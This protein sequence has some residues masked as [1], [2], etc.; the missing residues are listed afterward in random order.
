ML[1]VT[2]SVACVTDHA[3]TYQAPIR[4][5]RSDNQDLC[6][7]AHGQLCAQ[8][9]ANRHSWKR[10][11]IPDW[12]LKLRN[13]ARSQ[14]AS[15]AKAYARLYTSEPLIE[16]SMLWIVGGHQP[17]AFHPGVWY[18]NFLIDATAKELSKHDSPAVGLHVIIDHDLPKSLSIR[19]PYR[20][21]PNSDN[22]A[23][24]PCKLPIQKQNPSSHSLGP[25][26]SYRI[27]PDRVEPFIREIETAADSLGLPVPMARSYFQ[28]MSKL[29]A[30]LDAAVALSQ[31]RHKMENEHHLS[32]IDLPMSQICQTGAWFEFVEHCISHAA[33]LNDTYNSAL[34]AYREREKITN[35]GQPV[36]HLGRISDWIELPFWLYQSGDAGRN[37]M[38]VR[39]DAKTWELGSGVR[40][41]EFAWTLRLDAQIGALQTAF[42]Q[43]SDRGLCIR[44]RALMTTLFLRCFIADGFVHGIGGGI[45]DRLTDE[46]IRGLLHIEPPRYAIATATLQLPLPSHL[47]RGVQVAEEE[48][49]ALTKQARAARSAPETFLIPNDQQHRLL[50]QQHAELLAAIPPRGA[51]KLWHRQ[52]KDLKARIGQAIAPIV[53]KQ[54][55]QLQ[56]AQRRAHEAQWLTS[57]EYSMLVFPESD[58]IERLKLLA[59]QVRA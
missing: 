27:D 3:Q 50:A 26:H 5:P 29:D 49:R 11:S 56:S 35:P 36:A 4:T 19:L 14:V 59:S 51:K 58:C 31:A 12:I 23:V 44:P 9:L 25:W 37:R 8:V 48:L 53:Q 42:E 33:G 34:D 21:D 10:D 1:L 47:R 18:K 54:H 40:P 43:G 45:Y 17:E 6:I 28:V 7:P 2:R 16:P 13:R 32:N 20:P 15:A 46:I 24:G 52:M 38:W 41:E 22:L 57:R 39:S 30:D 55:V